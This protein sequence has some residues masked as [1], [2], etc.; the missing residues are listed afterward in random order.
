MTPLRIH[1][2]KNKTTLFK[3]SSCW[4][5][6]LSAVLEALEELLFRTDSLNRVRST[7]SSQPLQR[8][9]NSVWVSVT[10]TNNIKNDENKVCV[11]N[12]YESSWSIFISCV[13][14]Q[15]TCA[16]LL[17]AGVC[18]TLDLGLQTFDLLIVVGPLGHDPHGSLQLGLLG[19]RVVTL[20]KKGEKQR[21][22]STVMFPSSL[23]LYS[24]KHFF[25]IKHCSLGSQLLLCLPSSGS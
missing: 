6:C 20:R 15:I 12:T 25:S 10:E 11:L 3:L 2:K 23:S 17:C 1:Y 8:P 24:S 5:V 21:K 16:L 19:H 7:T 4:S 9:H 13:C 14:L 22:W 18:S